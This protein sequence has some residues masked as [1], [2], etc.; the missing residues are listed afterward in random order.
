[1][2]TDFKF[3]MDQAEQERAMEIGNSQHAMSRMCDVMLAVGSVYHEFIPR[4]F[5]QRM[6]D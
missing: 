1:M 5:N 3:S 2:M 6:T 4:K